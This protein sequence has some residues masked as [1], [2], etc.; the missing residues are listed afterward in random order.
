MNFSMTNL[1]LASL[2]LFMSGCGGHAV[3]KSSE[4]NSN[5]HQT[6]SSLLV[7]IDESHLRRAFL[8]NRNSFLAATQLDTNATSSA[9]AR[10]A[11]RN[12]RVDE[13]LAAQKKL[14]HALDAPVMALKG[15]LV[16]AFAVQGLGAEVQV[17][18]IDRDR[19]AIAK[20]ASKYGQKQILVLN[21]SAFQTN[22]AALYGRPYGPAH[23]T[24]RVS[25]DAR[26]FDRGEAAH[27]GAKPVWSAKTDFFLFSP[28]ECSSDAFKSCSDRFV[29]ALL[30]QMRVEG[31]IA[32]G[33]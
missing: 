15:S 2:L 33:K 20:I 13:Q 5:Y 4:K 3:I 12:A 30:Q 9:D 25:W 31:L 10:M 32:G 23:W 22:Q 8:Q 17:V 1:L 16:F 6:V 24:G 18:N 19:S 29:A 14:E 26:L 21:T 28:A 7:V 11:A 27:D